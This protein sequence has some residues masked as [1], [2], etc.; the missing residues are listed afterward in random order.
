LNERRSRF[1]TSTHRT[2]GL[3]P[4]EIWAVGYRYVENLAQHRRIQARGHCEAA[5]V[6]AQALSLDVNG[7]P[8]PRHVDVVGWP[9]SE[10]VQLAKATDIAEGMTLEVDPRL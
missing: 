2:K 9:D 4:G 5:L 6:T 8:Y 10:D 7:R 3:S 1:E